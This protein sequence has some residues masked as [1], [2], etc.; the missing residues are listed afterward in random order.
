MLGIIVGQEICVLIRQ[1]YCMAIVQVLSYVPTLLSFQLVIFVL[2]VAIAQKAALFHCCVQ[3]ERLEMQLVFQSVLSVLQVTFVIL[4]LQCIQTPFA[5]LA[6]S[7]L[8]EL[9]LLLNTLAPWAHTIIGV[10]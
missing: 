6:I 1:C 7:A 3:L 2:L 8:Q 9:H 10:G 4:A 5:L